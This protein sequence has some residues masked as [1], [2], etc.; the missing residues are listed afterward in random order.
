MFYNAYICLEM[1]SDLHQVRNINTHKPFTLI[2][3]NTHNISCH[4]WTH[5]LNRKVRES[6]LIGSQ[7]TST[8]CSCGLGLHNIQEELLCRGWAQ[9]WSYNVWCSLVELWSGLVLDH[10]KS[11]F[12]ALAFG[13]VILIL[14]S[15]IQ[16]KCIYC[17]PVGFFWELLTGSV[18]QQ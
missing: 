15:R 11:I 8:I 1:W 17:I 12:W 14:S 7:Q 3:H 6:V 10:F 13:A 9:T 18:H 16:A 5:S 2:K 4:C